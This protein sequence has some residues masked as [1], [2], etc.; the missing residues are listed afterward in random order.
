MIRNDHV[1]CDSCEH[2][3]FTMIRNYNFAFDSYEYENVL[4]VMRS[5]PALH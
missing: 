1:T 2:E 4:T 5:R 3:N